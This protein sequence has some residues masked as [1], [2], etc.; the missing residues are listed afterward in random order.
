M[1]QYMLRLLLCFAL[2]LQAQA[3]FAQKVG[4]LIDS[5]VTDRWALDR[6]LFCDKL[7]ELGGECVVGVAYGDPAEQYR[8]AEKM[9]NEGAKLLVVIP[10]DGNKAADIVALAKKS[11]TKVIAY[12]RMILHPDVALYV[13]YNSEKV[14]M[15]QAQYALS[16]H[17]KGNYVLLNGPVTD[18]NAILFREGQLKE[19]KPYIDKGS[20]SIVGDY[21][22]Q[23]WGEIGALLTM[24]EFYFSNKVKPQVILAAN[25]ALANGAIQALPSVDD[26][27][28]MVITGQDADLIAIK[29]IVAGIQAMT[30]YKPI[31]PLAELAA[32]A[33][34]KLIRGEALTNAKPMKF[35]SVTVPTVLLDPILVDRN[36][37]K[38]TVV[39]DGHVTLSE[40]EQ[41]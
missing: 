8:L 26:A 16:K 4:M 1:K 32:E 33:T 18:N 29:N 34:M 11:G 27:K 20:I 25:D 6:K 3:L 13:S 41:R 17:P 36:N 5:Y 7:S 38:E 37:F 12:D 31:K 23:D 30:I 2:V 22:M 35:Q 15:L 9:I 40:M 19:L 14:G 21:I 10:V 39:K 24:D 28:A